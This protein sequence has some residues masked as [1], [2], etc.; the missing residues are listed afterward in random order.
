M[1][2]PERQRGSSNAGDKQ[3][4][5]LDIGQWSVEAGAFALELCVDA[6]VHDGL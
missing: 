4:A 2:P 5:D 6:D 3:A 1:T